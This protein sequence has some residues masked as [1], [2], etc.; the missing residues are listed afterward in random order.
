MNADITGRVTRALVTLKTIEPS[1]PTS[2][3]SMCLVAKKMQ[4]IETT[5]VVVVL[6]IK[7]CFNIVQVNHFIN[8]VFIFPSSYNCMMR[9]LFEDKKNVLLVTL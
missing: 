4:N 8:A 2:S 5:N 3:L 1:S 6:N 9:T 7:T